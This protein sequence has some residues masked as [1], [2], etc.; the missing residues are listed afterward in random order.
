[1]PGAV[2]ER[3]GELEGLPQN[4]GEWVVDE[5]SPEAQGAAAR[6]LTRE[7]RTWRDPGKGWFGSDRLVLQVRY[8]DRATG[9]IQSAEPDREP[10]GIYLEQNYRGA[11]IV[12]ASQGATYLTKFV[13]DRLA[14]GLGIGR[15]L[16]EAVIR[17]H[18][19]VFWRARPQN[20][21]TQWYQS[22]CHGMVRAEGW[23]V[24][25]RGVAH[26]EIPQLIEQALALPPDF[27]S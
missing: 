2:E 7:R 4:L 11:A 5:S 26:T 10:T 18:E 1:V 8:R 25:W 16:W 20:P 13:V 23:M 22:Q 15:D 3:L 17:D 9:A 14:Q 12:S 21:I 19:K 6:G 27:E 24:Y